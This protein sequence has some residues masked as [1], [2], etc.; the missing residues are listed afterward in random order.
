MLPN[1]SIPTGVT[2]S[3][4]HVDAS[5]D[6]TGHIQKPSA[7]PASPAL[8]RQH[9][10]HRQHVGDVARMPCPNHG[11]PPASLSLARQHVAQLRWVP[12]LDDRTRAEP[13]PRPNGMSLRSDRERQ[14][15]RRDAGGCG[16]ASAP[17]ADPVCLFSRKT[18]KHGVAPGHGSGS[19]V[20]EQ[21]VRRKP[22]ADGVAAALA[23]AGTR[24]LVTALP[25]PLEGMTRP[26]GRRRCGR[27]VEADHP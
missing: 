3:G 24:W 8:R 22:R 7:S 13:S 20:P 19:H 17:L 5:A 6:R 1:L 15:A 23:P 14:G 11:P 21:L 27:P 16:P 9:G 18:D 12:L 26:R 10:R 4:P 25:G 2:T